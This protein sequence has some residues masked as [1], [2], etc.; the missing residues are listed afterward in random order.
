M[1]PWGM[2]RFIS[3]LDLQ[4]IRNYVDFLFPCKVNLSEKLLMGLK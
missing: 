4:I 1:S 3:N 2:L